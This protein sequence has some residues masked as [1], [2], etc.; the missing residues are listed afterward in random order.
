[1]EDFAS[2]LGIE[3]LHIDQGSTVSEELRNIE[4]Y[5]YPKKDFT[6]AG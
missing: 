1:M 6:F 4:V 3:F 2:I 5:Y